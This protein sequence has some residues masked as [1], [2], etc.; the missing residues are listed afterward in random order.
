MELIF[1][2]NIL[3]YKMDPIE[4]LR[5]NIVQWKDNQIENRMYSSPDSAIN[6]FAVFNKFYLY[7]LIYRLSPISEMYFKWYLYN[8]AS[9]AKHE[10]KKQSN[11]KTYENI[12]NISIR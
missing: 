12:G 2:N 9:K 11:K 1:K 6:T 8:I 10:K 7:F 4:G 5:K 3:K